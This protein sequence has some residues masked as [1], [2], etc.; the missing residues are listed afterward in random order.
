MSEHFIYLVENKFNDKLY[1]GQTQNLRERKR[2]HLIGESGAKLLNRAVKKYGSSNFEFILLEKCEGQQE[3]DSK[4]MYWIDKLYALSPVG[5]NLT[6]GGG[7][8]SGYCF[9]ETQK[10]NLSAALRGKKRSKETKEKIRLS[11]TG[12]KNPMYGKKGELSPTFGR[13]H[14]LE[15]KEKLSE[16]ARGKFF[17]KDNPN[18]GKRDEG[19]IWFGR[20]HSEETK[21]KMK[22]ARQ[23]WWKNR[24]AESK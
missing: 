6:K 1:I 15:T 11:K 16:I 3:A 19:S 12:H 21:I 23:L 24:K 20:R 9:S 7:G 14:S 13:K 10:E 8:V 22:E 2:R 18:Y 17:G 5:Y 4:E